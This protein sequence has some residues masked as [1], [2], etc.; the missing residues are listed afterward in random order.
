MK[1]IIFA[2][3]VITLVIACSSASFAY[4]EEV[5]RDAMI[6]YSGTDAFADLLPEER[7][8]CMIWVSD[9]GT[10]SDTCRSAVTKLISQEPN[11]VTREQ[12]RE[13]LAAASGRTIRPSAKSTA[14]SNSGTT[15]IKKDDNTGT[16]I[17]AGI[18]GVIAGMVIH[19]NLPRDRDRDCGPRYRY[20]PPPRRHYVVEHHVEHHFRPAPP[21]HIRREPPSHHRPHRR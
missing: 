11:I 17:A 5:A 18:I 20:C 12:R 8:A 14:P 3:T 19:N 10:M 4:N 2:L 1:K 21:M 6:I 15:V 9:G 13:L 7:Q 16:I